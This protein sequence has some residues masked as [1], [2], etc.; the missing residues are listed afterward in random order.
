MIEEDSELHACH[1]ESSDD[2]V[3]PS[4]SNLFMLRT[5][6][7]GYLCIFSDLSSEFGDPVEQSK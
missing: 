3:E 6:Q 2:F 7:R 1:G 5:C 4:S